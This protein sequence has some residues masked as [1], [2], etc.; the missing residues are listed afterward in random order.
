MHCSS[1]DSFRRGIEAG[2]S[3][4]SHLPAD[5]ALSPE[6]C[7]AFI[8]ADCIIEPTISCAYSLCWKIK[9]DSPK[10]HPVMKQLSD[11]RTNRATF[12]GIAEEFYIPGFRDSVLDS[13]T[14]YSNERFKILSILNATAVFRRYSSTIILYGIDNCKKLYDLGATMALAN[15][16]GAVPPCT[17]PMMGLEIGL[18]DLF[19]NQGADQSVFRGA[20]A[21]KIATFN[22]ARSMGLD[23][24]FGTLETGKVADIALVNGN[25]FEDLRIVGS[26]VDALFMDGRLVINNCGLSVEPVRKN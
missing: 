24:R 15:D 2:V 11:Y 3:S 12:A 22:S 20:D 5:A 16:G 25:P 10:D 7:K 18:F 17:P 14:N 6:D 4:I 9:D 26:R 8:E 1:I 13:Y 19:L 23:R 21:I